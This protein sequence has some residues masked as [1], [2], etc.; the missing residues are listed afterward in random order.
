[1]GGMAQEMIFGPPQPIK[2]LHSQTGLFSRH[3]TLPGYTEYLAGIT[4]FKCISFR[5]WWIAAVAPMLM[6]LWK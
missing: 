3:N 6:I 2:A 4:S 1:M 5:L